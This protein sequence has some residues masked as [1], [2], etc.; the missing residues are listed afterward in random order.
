MIFLYFKEKRMKVT[1]SFS[2]KKALLLTTA[3]VCCLGLATAVLAATS[4]AAATGIGHVADNVKSNLK[5]LA[6]MITAASYVAGMGFAIAAI[7]K[8]KAHKDNAAQ[9]PI[10]QPIAM[11]F[12]GAALLFAPSVFKTTGQTLFGASGVQAGISGVS[13]F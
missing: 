7:V 9:I 8:F 5:G 4:G 1:S 2:L 11:L 6:Y 3:A 12:I 10:S 13:S